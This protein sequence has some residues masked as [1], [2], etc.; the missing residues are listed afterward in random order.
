MER[1]RSISSCL[2]AWYDRFARSM[3]WRGICNPYYTWIS[4]TMLQ[5]TRVETVIPYYERFI[6]RFPTLEDLAAANESDV[7]KMWEG[8]GYYSRARN[9]LKGARQVIEQYGGKLPEGASELQNISGIGPYTAGAVASIAYGI[10]VPAVDGNVL[11]V[12]AR[13]FGIR[14]TSACPV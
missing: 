12:Y 14:K 4:E 3:P 10:P 11:R 1:F 7:L 6:S 2:L 5:Q 8:L 13:I 9:L